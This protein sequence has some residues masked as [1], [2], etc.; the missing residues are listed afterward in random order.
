MSIDSATS[1]FGL[2]PASRFVFGLVGIIAG[3]IVCRLVFTGFRVSD[4][5]MNPNYRN[6]DRV[7]A[8]RIG[9]P[10]TGDVVLV[11]SPVEPGKYLLKRVAAVEGDVVELRN[12]VIYINNERAQFK[13]KTITT[14]NR[15]FPMSFSG[16]D[17]MTAVKIER[18]ALFLLGDNLDYS[19]DS[20]EF[21]PVASGSIIGRVIYR[22]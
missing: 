13:W 5:S 7:Y 4:A 10:R 2:P 3:F 8:L 15:V 22:Y 1:R 21:G 20:R 17:N 12:R 9:T 14:D 11:E 19:L 18:H 16:R 6:G